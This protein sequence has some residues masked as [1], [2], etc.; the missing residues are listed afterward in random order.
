MKLQMQVDFLD[1]HKDYTVCF[2][3]V[4]IVYE[5]GTHKDEVYPAQ[6]EGFTLER[7]VEYNFIQTNSVLYRAATNYDDIP[8]DIQPLDWYLHLF[9]ANSG[10][11]G[12]IDKTMSV[13]RRHEGGIWWM[14]DSS[15]AEYNFLQKNYISHQRFYARASSL[16]NNKEYGR[17]MQYQA[18]ALLER[19]I[20][21]DID[22]QQT[23]LAR[24]M[25][26]APDT[27]HFALDGAADL[28]SDLYRLS[29]EQSQLLTQQK[30]AIE[31]LDKAM[32][33]ILNSRTYKISKTILKPL[34]AVKRLVAKT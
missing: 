30:M 10:G 5:N 22:K 27:L 33:V 19:V 29:H 2:H 17:Q 32:E 11:I 26:D 1:A 7:L 8:D 3:P 24:F 25:K 34:K 15:E 28:I 9:H 6:K 14:D 13:Y 18:I 23:L 12:F 21:L 4:R 20:Q 16:L 31:R